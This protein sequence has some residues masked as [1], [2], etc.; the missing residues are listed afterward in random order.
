MRSA[1]KDL[2]ESFRP[3]L[4]VGVILLLILAANRIAGEYWQEQQAKLCVA[5]G[6]T[7]ILHGYYDASCILK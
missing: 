7:V 1:T 5:R 2:W 6:G 4:I 3:I